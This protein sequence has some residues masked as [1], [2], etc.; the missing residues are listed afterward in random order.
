MICYR[1]NGLE[2]HQTIENMQYLIKRKHVEM[3]QSARLTAC[4]RTVDFFK[5]LRIND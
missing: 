4:W 3:A 5:Y 1:S 2:Y